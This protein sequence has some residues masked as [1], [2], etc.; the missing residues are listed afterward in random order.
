V[1]TRRDTVRIRQDETMVEQ[2]RLR[3]RIESLISKYSVEQ[4][5]LENRVRLG[6][7]IDSLVTQLGLI[8]GR[9]AEIS[10]RIAG[11]VA[12]GLVE[13]GRARPTRRIDIVT[14]DMQSPDDVVLKGWIGINAEGVQT[15]PRIR[16]GEIYL[17][18]VDYPRILT[19]EAN[20]PAARAGILKG[21]LLV[22]YDGADVR[23]NEINLT[24]LLRPLHQ[25]RVTVDRDGERHDYPVYVER[26]PASLLAR[27]MELGLLQ[28]TDTLAP[29]PRAATMM[30][31]RGG[32]G[33]RAGALA[34]EAPGGVRGGRVF[35]L[36]DSDNVPT[37]AV[38]PRVFVFRNFG[39][40]LV[41]AKME[42]VDQ[43]LGENFGV[44]S[45]VLLT[46]V[47][48]PSPARSSG[49]R[50]GDVIVRAN[51]EDVTSIAQL[52][53]IISSAGDDRRVELRV[54]RFK[55]TIPVTLRW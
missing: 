19:V 31:R 6:A 20:S 4:L 21:D 38:A 1:R 36:P 45:G 51:G 3:A 30:A 55:K 39:D 23:Q 24:Q 25:V 32:F 5:S 26:A 13:A 41:G 43:E 9:N 29:T 8:A 47:G 46:R 49:L 16:D 12:R 28:F 35:A 33:A 44:D 7:T 52:R 10:A 40:V 53:R 37:P 22:A 2:A 18:Y 34:P 17:R 50:S 27:R 11:G 15:P 42:V 14:G 54:V 48:D